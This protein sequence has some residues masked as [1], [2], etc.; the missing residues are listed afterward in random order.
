MLDAE[1]GG[2]GLPSMM[3]L[4]EAAE[5]GGFAI[6]PTGGQALLKAIDDLSTFIQTNLDDADTVAQQLPLGSSNGAKVM[7]PYMVNVVSDD[8]GF[9]TRLKEFRTSLEGASAAIKAAMKNYD[10]MDTGIG[11]NFVAI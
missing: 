6:S 8:Q 3:R 7:K 10:H 11:G 2:G 5:S 4:V 1:G 9:Y